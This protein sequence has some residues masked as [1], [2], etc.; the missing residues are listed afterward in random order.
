M[1]KNYP[2]SLAG[3]YSIHLSDQLLIPVRLIDTKP[4]DH[5]LE[6]IRFDTNQIGTA[7][8]EN[9]IS[10]SFDAKWDGVTDCY[11]FTFNGAGH[12]FSTKKDLGEVLNYV[13]VMSITDFDPGD[14]DN[15]K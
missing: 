8:F 12:V 4:N 1:S 3:L 7:V 11:S 15:C 6:E 14:L 5:L 2:R 10:V 9:G 13:D